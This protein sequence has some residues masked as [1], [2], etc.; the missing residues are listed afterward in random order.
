MIKNIPKYFE[1]LE[2]KKDI[3]KLEKNIQLKSGELAELKTKIAV[4]NS[5]LNDAERNYEDAKIKSDLFEEDSGLK[6]EVESKNKDL[7]KVEEKLTSIKSEI[8]EKEEKLNTM[9]NSLKDEYENG[10][11]KLFKNKLSEQEDYKTK[12]FEFSKKARLYGDKFLTVEREVNELRMQI[13]QTF[14]SI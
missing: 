1:E 6:K 2:N 12:Q 8:L 9:K 7:K 14:G 13:H 5:M 4:L 10:L 11:K 3:I